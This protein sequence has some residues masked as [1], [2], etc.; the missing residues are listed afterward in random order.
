MPSHRPSVARRRPALRAVLAGTLLAAG[1]LGGCTTS[2]SPLAPTPADFGGITQV[3]RV[4]GIL[5]SDVVSGDAGCPSPDLAKAAI[6]FTMTG[7]DQASP[8]SAYLYIFGDQAA[9]ERRAT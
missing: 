8:V 1:L 9:F 5:V 3:L 6:H 4:R 2:S 7:L